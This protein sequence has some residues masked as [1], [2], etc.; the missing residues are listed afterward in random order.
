MIHKELIS[1]DELARHVL[2]QFEIADEVITG[3]TFQNTENSSTNKRVELNGTI[4][5]VLSLHYKHISSAVFN[6]QISVQDRKWSVSSKAY[7][8]TVCITY[9]HNNTTKD[10]TFSELRQWANDFVMAVYQLKS[11][12]VH[13]I[14][15]IP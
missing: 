13:G 7:L 2:K 10:Y 8:Q 3:V 9:W 6:M 1:A 5:I 12:E 11:V 14:Q 4:N 15:I